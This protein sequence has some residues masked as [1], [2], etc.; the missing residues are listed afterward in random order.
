[1]NVINI[2]YFFRLLLRV[3]FNNLSACR[4]KLLNGLVYLQSGNKE[5]P[6]KIPNF[7]FFLMRS[8]FFFL[9]SLLTQ[10]G[11]SSPTLCRIKSHC[12]LIYFEF[13]PTGCGFLMSSIFQDDL[14]KSKYERAHC[15]NLSGGCVYLASFN[16]LGA[17][18]FSSLLS[19][20]CRKDLTSST[21]TKYATPVKEKRRIPPT[22]LLY[23]FSIF[24]SLNPSIV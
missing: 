21:K 14:L 11:Q 22:N 7:P 3:L 24:C 1:M 16:R 15:L 18:F 4:S 5:H 9:L 2:F 17:D 13:L 19:L 8:P 6:R 20:S 10:A 12:N 23:R